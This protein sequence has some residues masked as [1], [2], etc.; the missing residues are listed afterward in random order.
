MNKRPFHT[1]MTMNHHDLTPS[2]VGFTVAARRTPDTFGARGM[3]CGSMTLRRMV[4]PFPA[5]KSGTKEPGA[6]SND[7]VFGPAAASFGSFVT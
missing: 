5:F 3:P 4:W 2:G 1:V 7:V 6:F